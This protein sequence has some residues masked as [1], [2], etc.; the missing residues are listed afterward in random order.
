MSA[1]SDQPIGEAPHA[2]SFG[3]TLLRGLGFLLLL[4]V[5]L[6]MSGWLARGPLLRAAADAW[7]VSDP[8]APADAAAVFGGGVDDRPF[9]A[10]AYYHQGLVKRILLSDNR[11]STTGEHGAAPS[12]TA[13]NYKVL[14]NLGVPESAIETFG[15]GSSNTYEEALALRAWA[16][17]T[18]ARRVIVPTEIFSARRV[19]W[20]L[21]RIAGGKFA[22]IVPALGPPGYRRD[23][24]WRHLEGV[25]AFESEVVKY[26][27]YRTVY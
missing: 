13:A 10:A 3:A 4:M 9:A 24:W 1:S 2:R 19:R 20:V 12:D 27:Y 23:D 11:V 8:I 26:L 16:Q 25:I 22:V 21:H 15:K 7:I 17:R 6:G 14:R 5:A 18:G